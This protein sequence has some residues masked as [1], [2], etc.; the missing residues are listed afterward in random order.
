ME[1]TLIEPEFTCPVCRT[2]AGTH[3][4]I[5]E[6]GFIYHKECAKDFLHTKDSDV[7]FTS[8][9]T[10][11]VK[12]GTFITSKVIE[13]TINLLQQLESNPTNADGSD[14]DVEDTIMKA[15]LGDTYHMAVLGRWHLFGEKQGV[16]LD[17]NRGYE[18]VRKSHEQHCIEGTAYYGH[19]LIRGLGTDKNFEVGKAALVDAACE[20]PSG[21]AKD[22]AAYTLGFCRKNNMHGF[23]EDTKKA[24]KWLKRVVNMPDKNKIWEGYDFKDDNDEEETQASADQSSILPSPKNDQDMSTKRLFDDNH[25]V[26]TMLTASSNGN[27]LYSQPQSSYFLGLSD[28]ARKECEVCLK[29]FEL[30][31]MFGTRCLTCADNE[32]D[33]KFRYLS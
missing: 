8:P 27:S 5:A 21:D 3:P 13:T 1:S 12:G 15:K 14:E 10:G 20:A 7:T 24:Q 4:I 18:L 19:C 26:A 28:N 23:K 31:G 22:F 16:E 32:W 6:D 17:V 9:M 33:S 11:E 30:K 25:T 2:L 29:S